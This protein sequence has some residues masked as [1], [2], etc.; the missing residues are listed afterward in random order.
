MWLNRLLPGFCAVAALALIG[1]R[2]GA[3]DALVFNVDGSE[4]LEER[5]RAA[6]VLEQSIEAGR[7]APQDLLAAAQAEYRALVGALYAEGHYSG[8]VRVRVDGREAADLSPL[9]APAQ[10]GQIT[11]T[12]SPGPQFRFSLARVAPL[13]AS[14]EPT[15][16]FAAGEPARSGVIG[17]AARAGV[18]AWRADGHAKADIAGQSITAD[19]PARTLAADVALAPGP[20]LRFGP[21]TVSGNTRVRE[22]RIREIAGLPEGQVYSP[23]V[24]RK[25]ADRLRRTGAFRSVALTDGKEIINGDQLPIDAAVVE[26]KRR[27]LGV[28]VELSSQEGLTLSAFW[29][30]RNLFGGAERLRVD[31]EFGQIGGEG[32]DGD[33]GFDSSIAFRFDRPATFRPDASFFAEGA[34]ERI[35]DPG[36]LSSSATL[37]AGLEYRFSDILTASAGLQ[38]RFANIEDTEGERDFELLSIPLSVTR[39]TRD[40][41]LNATTGTFLDLTLQPFTGLSGT[42]DGARLTFDGRGYLSLGERAVVAGRLQLG[43]LWG[44]EAADAPEDF[45]F[46]AGGGGTVRGQPFQALGIEGGD[47]DQSGG[48]SFVGLS[49]ELRGQVT[50]TIGLVGFV[51]AGYIGEESFYDGTG[52]VITG[53]GIGVRYETGI[54]PIRFD[55]GAP[56][57]GGPSDAPEVQIY[58]GIGQAF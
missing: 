10:I 23:E 8:T 49:A 29:I 37:G 53:A 41:A 17:D 2:A 16:G 30:H 18:D 13:P 26:E 34:L 20:R 33:N 3:L 48:R 12:V 14:A 25:S 19:H 42:D 44:P 27:R 36:F 52:E 39:D 22:G 45:L 35:D 1:V 21:L 40:V 54:G 4:T 28:G 51:D 31:L 5:L 32:E 47:V 56:V 15:P 58:I 57:S 46:F 7:T 24:L 11:V 38:Y 50:D 43:A 9:A 6:S 55:I